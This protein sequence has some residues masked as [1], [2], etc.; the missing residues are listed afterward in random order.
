[1]WRFIVSHEQCCA[2]GS[3]CPARLQLGGDGEWKKG[4]PAELEEFARE[5]VTAL[6]RR[7][8]EAY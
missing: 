4:I 3:N 8:T 6:V 5:R 7:L 1:M 2:G